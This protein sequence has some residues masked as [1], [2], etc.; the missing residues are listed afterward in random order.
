MARTMMGAV[1]LLAV[2]A[3]AT[4][5]SASLTESEAPTRAATYEP[6]RPKV[7]PTAPSD[8]AL[9]ARFAPNP[10][11]DGAINYELIDE[12]LDLMVFNAGPS[13]RRRSSRPDAE[14]GTRFAKGHESPYRLEGNKVFFSQFDQEV[15]DAVGEY[16][17]SLEQIGASG[18]VQSL[19]RNE[20]LAYWYNLHNFVV[21]DE[22]AQR[23]PV[24]Q[25]RDLK[26]GPNGE[27]FHEAKVVDLGDVGLNLREVREIVY[28]HW[29]DPKVMY[30]FYLGD[31]GGP[32]IRD[33][34]YT[35]ANVGTALSSQAR[36]FVNSLRGVSRGSGNL[37][38][39][40]FYDEGR[41]HFFPD[42]PADIRAHVAKYADDEVEELLA[43]DRPLRF[44]SYEPDIADMAGG[45]VTSSLNVTAAPGSAAGSP[46]PGVPEGVAR[47]AR[48]F[49]YK[50]EELRRDG[51][52]R[53][54]VIIIDVPTEDEDEG[55]D[56]E[57]D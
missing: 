39:S 20:Q 36:E 54:R 55:A 28:A 24:T 29:D 1:S 52:L 15:I 16:R 21:I 8:P 35:G 33:Q 43:E 13:L 18:K 11:R 46:R 25:P 41:P 26:I 23:Y 34:A 31:I 50:L 17:R 40:A 27:S 10:S 30:G 2:C 6:E 32:S 45:D 53:G 48:E 9:V 14:V 51:Y 5:P 12:A 49:N 19:P 47:M 57:V 38:V 3:C 56:G 37:Y 42:W 4:T 22:I 44:A 7:S